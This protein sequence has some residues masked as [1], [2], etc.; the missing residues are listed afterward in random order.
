MRESILALNAKVAELRQ[1]LAEAETRAIQ[2]YVTLDD[3]TNL[4]LLPRRDYNGQIK[5]EL[6]NLAKLSKSHLRAAIPYVTKG[7]YRDLTS[8]LAS[9]L[10]GGGKIS[11]MFRR[12]ETKVDLSVHRS[13]LKSYRREI[14]LG[15]LLVRYMGE[16]G[17]NGLHAKVVIADEKEALVSSANLTGYALTKNVEVG[18]ATPSTRI[19]HALAVWFDTVFESAAT[20]EEAIP[21]LESE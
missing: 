14:N 11:V 20:P 16:E 17:R 1:Q 3:A 10:E 18:L 13:F 2:L 12:P 6:T 4:R 9:A 21:G 7:G 15:R 5:D 19:V 8:L